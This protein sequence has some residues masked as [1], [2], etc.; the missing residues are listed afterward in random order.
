MASRIQPSV[1]VRSDSLPQQLQAARLVVLANEW[2]TTHQ[3]DHVI[4][5]VLNGGG[6]AGASAAHLLVD[7]RVIS[8]DQ[9]HELDEILRHQ[10]LFDDYRLLRKLGSGGMGTVFLAEHLADGR[11][12]AMKTMNAKLADD[13]DFIG[14]FHR[15]AKA[16][17]SVKHPNIAEIFGSGEQASHC[18]LAMEFIDGPSLM[19][20]LRDY[21]AL[22]EGYSLSIIHQIA[23][24]LAHVW[25]QAHLVHR[26]IKPENILVV[27]NRA[28]GGDLFPPDD[29]AKLIDFGL[30]KSQE[31]DDRLTQTGMTIG[32]PLYMSPEQVRGE[33]LDCRSDIYGLGATLYHLLTGLTPFTGTSPGSIM[34]AHLT[35]PVPDPG[36]RVPSLHQATRDLVRMCMAKDAKDRFLTFEALCQAIDQ[37]LSTCGGKSGSNLRLLRK[38]LVLNKPQRKAAEPPKAAEAPPPA[39]AKPTSD[40]VN[41]S[42]SQA[43]ERVH[44]E[45]QGRSTKDEGRRAIAAPLTKPPTTDTTARSKVFDEDP[46]AKMGMGLLPW[47]VLGAALAGLAAWWL[48][49][50]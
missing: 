17:A 36:E 26:D 41:K 1:A 14:R 19:H 31:N 9:A 43:L 25:N 37:A 24:G 27:R 39:E 8:R 48:L 16:L 22:P 35:E 12:V 45:R 32:T 33:K 4:G 28:G 13:K 47:I 49:S 34:S 40:R 29:H 23:E 5:Q 21:R 20:L 50:G 15:E 10:A 3:L 11:Q 42:G 2:A 38:P 44:T 46:H 30:V 7:H 18:W 6:E